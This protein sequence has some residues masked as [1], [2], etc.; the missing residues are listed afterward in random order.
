MRALPSPAG[1]LS[2]EA[3]RQ[4]AER[5]RALSDPSRLRLLNVLMGGERTVQELVDATG[6]GQ[7]NVSRRLALRR[8]AGVVSRRPEGRRA[9][10]RIADPSIERLCALVCGSLAEQR[11]GELEAFAGSGI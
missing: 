10:Y 7:A 1:L 8:R 11:A 3:L 4:V 9:W 5:F 6:L 2:E